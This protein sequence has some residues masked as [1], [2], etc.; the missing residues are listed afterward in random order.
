MDKGPF[1]FGCFAMIFLA[2]VGPF[3]IGVRELRFFLYG[4][5]IAFF[6]YAVVAWRII[7]SLRREDKRQQDDEDERKR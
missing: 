6:L 7:P 1:V 2:L 3:I 5:P 4:V